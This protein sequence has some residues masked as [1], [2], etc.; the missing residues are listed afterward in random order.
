MRQRNVVLAVALF[1]SFIGRNA[2]GGV[3]YTVTALG[4]GSPTGINASGQV[5]GFVGTSTA[6]DAFLYSN[7]TMTDLGTLGGSDSYAYGINDNGQIVGY[8]DRGGIND[9]VQAFLYSNGTTTDL[10]PWA[11]IGIN[12]SGEV[13]G[14]SPNYHACL[15]SN[16]TTTDLGSWRAIGINDS[17]VVVGNSG[18]QA[19]LY[20]NGTMT[21]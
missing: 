8:T 3:Q 14:N 20:S 15:Y 18:N 13:V 11:A 10:G 2:W 17:G 12:K 7:G 16:G 1:L 21:D 6:T 4:G 9:N 5:V 19:C